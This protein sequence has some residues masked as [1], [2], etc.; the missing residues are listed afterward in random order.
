MA[1]IRAG[2]TRDILRQARPGDYN[3]G[4]NANGLTF[5]TMH[6]SAE[7]VILREEMPGHVV[8]EIF[9]SVARLQDSMR[10]RRRGGVIK[11]QIPTPLYA[12][13]QKEWANGPKK[14]G[15]LWKAFLAG[16]IEDRDYRKFLVKK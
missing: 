8:D 4:W 9:A 16:K 14:W 15:V 5:S 2:L 12:A 1:G 13:W 3:L 11:G 7:E 10:G 6:I